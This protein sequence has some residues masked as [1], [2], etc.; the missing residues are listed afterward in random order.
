MTKVRTLVERLRARLITIPK[1]GTEPRV[2]SPNEFMT[3]TVGGEHH[4]GEDAGEIMLPNVYGA[5]APRKQQH[6]YAVEPLCGEAADE[7]ELLQQD[8]ERYAWIRSYKPHLIIATLLY[9]GDSMLDL[10]ADRLDALIDRELEREKTRSALEPDCNDA[11]GGVT[12]ITKGVGN[13]EL[14]V[15][16]SGAPQW[17]HIRYGGKEFKF[18]ALELPDLEYVVACAQRA[19]ALGEKL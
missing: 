17:I 3:M 10:T 18:T 8:A 13:F 2:I 11:E 7:I 19:I 5:V 1:P 4:V 16:E 12:V 15:W 9:E 6:I 14:E